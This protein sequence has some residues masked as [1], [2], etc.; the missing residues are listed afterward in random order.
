MKEMNKKPKLVGTGKYKAVK[1][2][3]IDELFVQHLNQVD[4]DLEVKRLSSGQYMFGTKRIQV[5]IIND[6]LLIRV[7]GGYMS[8]EEFIE[9]Y[10]KME[11]LKLA[12]QSQEGIFKQKM[13]L[14]NSDYENLSC[15]MRDKMKDNLLNANVYKVVHNSSE[16]SSRK[17]F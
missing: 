13:S 6:K 11:M 3:E 17:T 8:V 7:G 16:R 4:I 1:G 15:K 14:S 12:A 5:K 9:Q 2:D 10:G